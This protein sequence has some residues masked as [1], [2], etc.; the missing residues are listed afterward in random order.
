[1]PVSL[2]AKDL[3]VFLSKGL[4]FEPKLPK[5]VLV[6]DLKALFFE[7]LPFSLFLELEFEFEWFDF[8]ELSKS[9]LLLEFES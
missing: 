3:L 5:G 1:M 8:S 4:E 9:E 6:C 2:A 7:D